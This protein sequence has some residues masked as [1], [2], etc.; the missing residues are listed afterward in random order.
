MKALNV[1]FMGQSKYWWIM[2]LVGILLVL[3][4]FAY[5]FWPAA[6]YA[7]ASQLF[8]WLLILAG[9]VQLCVSAGENRPQGWGWWIVGGVIDIFIGFML[10]RSV[11]LSEAVFPYFLAIIFIFW[12]ISAITNSVAVRGYRYWWL[13]LINGVL[14]LIIGFF[15][16]EAGY[17]QNMIM[18]SFLTA[19]SF[20]YWGFSIA[21]A[22]YDMK[23]LK[24]IE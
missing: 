3:G 22:A 18:V 21:M 14:L 5:W 1:N 13:H 8:G 15:F 2:L 17:V 19:V 16:L 10:V 23:P 9:V 7:V 24:E 12:G 11:I 4:G 20:I 6:G